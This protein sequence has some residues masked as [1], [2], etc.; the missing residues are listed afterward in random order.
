MA[1]AT[2]NP[3]YQVKACAFGGS[4]SNVLLKPSLFV[5]EVSDPFHSLLFAVIHGFHWTKVFSFKPAVANPA[6]LSLL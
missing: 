5:E 1:E 2:Q 4:V 3:K 6:P